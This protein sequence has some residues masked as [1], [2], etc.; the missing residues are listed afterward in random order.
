MG[1]GEGAV[2]GEGGTDVSV[3][4]GA[5]S[6][7]RVAVGGMVE[8][9]VGVNAAAGGS[10]LVGTGGKGVFAG[11]GAVGTVCALA[12]PTQPGTLPA[13]ITTHRTNPA[14]T[15]IRRGSLLRTCAIFS[16]LTAYQSRPPKDR[17]RGCPGSEERSGRLTGKGIQQT[18][19]AR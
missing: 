11:G 6:A 16:L 2:V 5:D 1:V 4:A 19:P 15:M 8:V 10:V 9:A 12:V 7:V 3:S 18:M 17:A 14:A 13:R